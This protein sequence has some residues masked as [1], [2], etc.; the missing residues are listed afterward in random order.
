LGELTVYSGKELCK[1]LEMHDF[2]QVRQK[3]SH[4]VMQKKLID[5]TITVPIPNHREIKKGTLL[6]IIRQSGI[7]RKEFE[8]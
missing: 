1:I 8:R 5:S 4:I 7:S 2:I 6:S 3:G